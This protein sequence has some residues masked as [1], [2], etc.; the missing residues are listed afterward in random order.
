MK[1][2]RDR[3]NI[4][5]EAIVQLISVVELRA[6]VSVKNAERINEEIRIASRRT[7]HV[8]ANSSPRFLLPC[9][10]LPSLGCSERQVISP[11]FL[12]TG[13]HIIM[14]SLDLSLSSP[15]RS[16]IGSAVRSLRRSTA[17]LV[18]ESTLNCHAPLANMEL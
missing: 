8:Y 2:F 7:T 6:N 12:T 5:V 9:D 14:L 3:F 18:S 17:E 10:A 13:C 4:E 1:G 11:S 15:R 16:L